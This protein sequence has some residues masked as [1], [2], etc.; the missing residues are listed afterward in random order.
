MLAA[1]DI[2]RLLLEIGSPA[3]LLTLEIT[4]SSV[5]SDPGRT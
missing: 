1:D 3:E 5:M 2:A 4:E